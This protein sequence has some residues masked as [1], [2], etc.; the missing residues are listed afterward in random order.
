MSVEHDNFSE[1]RTEVKTPS[2]QGQQYT[3]RIYHFYLQGIL[4]E[5]P[6]L[7]GNPPLGPSHL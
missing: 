2:Y 7:W 4:Q 3:S 1:H 6:A 5:T